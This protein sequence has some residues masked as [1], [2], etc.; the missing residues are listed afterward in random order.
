MGTR[1]KL[2]ILQR[3]HMDGQKNTWKDVQDHSLL[4]KC[5]SKL[6]WGISPYTS[7]NGIIK[8]LANNKMLEM[9]QRN[10]NSPTPLVE[11][12]AGATTMENS[13]EVPSKSKYRTTIWSRI[14]TP[15]HLSGQNQNSQRYMHSNVHCSTIYNGQ[16]REAIW[17]FTDRGMDKDVVHIYTIKY[18]SAI[19]RMKWCHLQQPG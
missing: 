18:Y 17:M 6:Q 12:Y 7:Q 5:K 2:T 4:E 9:V 11:I 3:R 14:P 10:G 19:K 16:A 13:M 15:G 1:S 8:T